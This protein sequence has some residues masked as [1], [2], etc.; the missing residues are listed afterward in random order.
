M[1]ACDDLALAIQQNVGWIAANRPSFQDVAGRTDVPVCPGHRR[2]ILKL[3]DRVDIPIDADR[4]DFELI[5]W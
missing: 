2:R 3:D 4:D 1:R 5:F